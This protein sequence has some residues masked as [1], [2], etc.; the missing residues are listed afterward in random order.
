M[1]KRWQPRSRWLAVGLALLAVGL[2]L[3]GCGG[4]GEDDRL[5][6]GLTGLNGETVRLSQYRGQVVLLNFWASWCPPCREEMPA[7]DTLQ[8]AHA[9]AGLVVLA[10]NV[11]ETR[12]EA[13]AFMQ[14][15]G[16]DLIVALDPDKEVTNQ[17]GVRNLP[18]SIVVDREGKIAQRW[19]GALT[20]EAA[21]GLVRPLLEQD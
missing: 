15:G 13:Q 18:T 5:D 20:L 9:G 4:G 14:E 2:W 8:A 1:L 10:V 6:F 12:A 7:L 21:E 19:A 17:F 11:A 16:Y 3:G